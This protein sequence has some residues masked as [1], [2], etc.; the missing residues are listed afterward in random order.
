MGPGSWQI[1]LI[2]GSLALTLIPISQILSRVGFS[3]WWTLAAILCIVPPVGLILLWLFA[4]SRWPND[5]KFYP[6]QHAQR[7][8]EVE[9]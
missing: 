1:I 5:R 9:K 7:Q 4:Y 8:Q 2:V 3:R 6:G